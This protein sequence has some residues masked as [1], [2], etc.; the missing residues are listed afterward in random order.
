MA[1]ELDDLAP[2]YQPG[3]RFHDENLA[4]LS[5]CVERMLASLRRS[6]ARSLVSLGIGHEVVSRRLIDAL[7]GS[8]ESYTIVE[9]SSAVI[10][11]FT[12]AAPL[13][14]GVRVVHALFE[15][16]D[17]GAPVDAV[18]MGFVLEHV[19][20]AAALLRRYE[21]FLVPGGTLFVAVPNARSLHRLFGHA[22][23]LLDDVYRL[24]PEDRQLG[25]RRYFDL[26]SIT[27]LVEDSGLRV[28]RGEGV[29]LKCLTSSQLDALELPPAVRRAFY[30][31]G[32]QHP[33][34]CNA[35]FL[36]TTR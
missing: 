29:F 14:P 35:L 36:E 4:M 12:A 11:R 27:R 6:G 30:E 9:G 2:A 5:W 7:A 34:I 31:V 28:V 13:P 18:E 26:A 33:D 1:H 19:E 25:H 32:V 3:F 21:G 24:S 17:P 23:G 10:D 20:D 15:D 8:L 16:F 22:A